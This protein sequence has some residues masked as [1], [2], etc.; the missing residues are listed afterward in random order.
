MAITR[1]R[2]LRHKTEQMREDLHYS[3][4]HWSIVNLNQTCWHQIIQQISY[5]FIMIHGTV[6]AKYTREHLLES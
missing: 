2:D 3:A 5:A 1:L 4:M 6:V